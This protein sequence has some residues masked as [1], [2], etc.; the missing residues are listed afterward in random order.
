MTLLRPRSFTVHSWTAPD[1][2]PVEQIRP[3]AGSH[4]LLLT[5]NQLEHGTHETEPTAVPCRRKRG[6]CH[7]PCNGAGRASIERWRRV[8]QHRP[9]PE[10]RPGRPFAPLPPLP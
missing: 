2:R 1:D 10:R 3:N 8:A 6:P 4:D 9:K 5:G 7:E